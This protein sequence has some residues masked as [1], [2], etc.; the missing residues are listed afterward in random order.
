L[1]DKLGHLL[2]Q[3]STEQVT[4][5]LHH[6]PRLHVGHSAHVSQGGYVAAAP[7]LTGAVSDKHVSR[8]PDR[9]NDLGEAS[10]YCVGWFSQR[11]LAA[12][13]AT[14]PNYRRVLLP[15]DVAPVQGAQ[16]YVSVHGVIG[17]G[18]HA[19]PF[20]PQRELYAWL[21]TRLPCLQTITKGH[22]HPYADPHLRDQVRQDLC[23]LGLVAPSGFAQPSVSR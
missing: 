3:C 19:L 16:A 17:E 2:G 13:D 5:G 9:A 6:I 18:A 11:L 22:P 12:L 14:E 4:L 20:L 10:T 23:R 21:R 8:P 15:A 7:F 1:I